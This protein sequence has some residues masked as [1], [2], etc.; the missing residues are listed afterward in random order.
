MAAG[1]AL[2]VTAWGGAAAALAAAACV[3]WWFTPGED[4]DAWRQGPP[5]RLW[6]AAQRQETRW[7][8]EGARRRIGNVYVPL[9]AISIDLQLAVLVSEDIDFFGHGPID[10]DAV[11]EA[12]EE[13]SRPGARLRGASTISQQLAKALFLS[14]ERSLW[15]KLKEVHLAWWLERK[16]GKR[17]ILEL[18]LNVVE[19]GPGLFGA[20]AATRHYF[21][22]SSADVG[23]EQASAL[24]A[25]IPSPGRDNP[26]SASR[27]W[28]LRRAIILRRMGN[29]GWLRAR[30]EFMRAG[31]S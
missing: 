20:E 13:G 17:R 6:A 21:K 25:A 18:Y 19:F 23:P 31:K 30:L 27:R 16:L 2:R 7:R 22:A 11:L 15:R 8:E 4:L 5:D 29:A 12:L 10:V 9:S 28:D 14:G 3:G 1:R 24:V 26:S